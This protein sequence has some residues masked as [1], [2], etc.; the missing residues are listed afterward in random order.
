[1]QQRMTTTVIERGLARKA[2]LQAD[3]PQIVPHYN[4]RGHID[5]VTIQRVFGLP[6][7]MGHELLFRPDLSRILS[8]TGY[9]VLRRS[10]ILP[11][12]MEDLEP[13]RFL[14]R[15]A[16]DLAD[17]DVS[18]TEKYLL[19]FL[20]QKPRVPQQL[21]V[22]RNGFALYSG[23][24]LFDLNG[25]WTDPWSV[26]LRPLLFAEDPLG[27]NCGAIWLDTIEDDGTLVGM[28]RRCARSRPIKKQGKRFRQPSRLD[29]ESTQWREFAARLSLIGGDAA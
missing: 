1:M 21:S 14:V 25:H 28:A 24:A 12:P 26:D 22:G 8:E 7:F 20:D 19:Q 3:F 6:W 18:R 10:V 2:Q 15:R 4:K 16:L 13:V 23:S 5:R 9:P 27:Q 29:P 17:A 11:R